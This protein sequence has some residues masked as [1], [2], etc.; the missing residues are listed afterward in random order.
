MPKYAPGCAGSTPFHQSAWKVRVP[1][2]ELTHC[3]L[4]ACA[5]KRVVS[6]MR[7]LNTACAGNISQLPSSVTA[8]VAGELV[9]GTLAVVLGWLTVVPV[10]LASAAVPPD[11]T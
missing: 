8:L 2:T 9:A 1:P 6:S 4:L 10:L 3:A 11:P 7:V 5:G